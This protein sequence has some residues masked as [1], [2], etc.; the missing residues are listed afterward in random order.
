MG[1]TQQDVI[2]YLSGRPAGITL[3]HGKAGCGK[4]WL[5][6]KIR[7]IVPGCVVLTPTNLASTL[8]EGAKTIHSFFWRA[9]DDLD[10]GYQDPGNVTEAKVASMRPMLQAVSMLVFDEV[11]R[12]RWTSS[13]FRPWSTARP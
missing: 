5:I 2:D 6:R 7:D 12:I 13:S 3:V 10:E 4:T 1:A 8:Y 9:F 11:S